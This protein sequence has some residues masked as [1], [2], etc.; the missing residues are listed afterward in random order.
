[1]KYLNTI[2]LFILVFSFSACNTKKTITVSGAFALYPLAVKWGQE[3]EKTHPNV[4]VD[5]SAGGTGKGISDVLSDNAEIGMVSREVSEEELKKGTWAV[6]VT[7]DAVIPTINANNPYLSKILGTGLTQQNFGDIWVTGKIKKWAQ[8]TGDSSST[9]AIQVFTRSDAAGAPEIWAKYLGKKQEDL[10]GVGIF[11]DPGLAEAVKKDK[12]AVGFN[13]LAFIYS[14]DT[15]KPFDG[16]QPLPIDINGNGTL[17]STENFYDNMDAVIEAIIKGV[18]PS[19]P[20]RDLYF[21][22]KGKPT[23][24]AVKEF[25]EWVLTEGQQYVASSGYVKFPESKIKEE[26]NKL[27]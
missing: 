17:D 3:Y 22:T 5:V 15:K 4:R 20:A 1:M 25:I 9:N 2:C 8:L 23:D 19:P 7:K 27:K 21:I 6:A 24:P 14:L 10:L 26:K 12:F 13:N 11:G 18:Y 16:I